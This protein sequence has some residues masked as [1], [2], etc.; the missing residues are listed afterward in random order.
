MKKS[1]FTDSRIIAVLKRAEAGAPVPGPC[2]EHG[3]GSAT[4]CKWRSRFGSMFAAP[5]VQT[6]P[7]N[8]GSGSIPGCDPFDP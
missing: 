4:F 5:E 7:E 2:R 8:N 3:I 1:R 6:V